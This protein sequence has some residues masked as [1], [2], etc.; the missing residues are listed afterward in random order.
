MSDV[1]W[2]RAV[3]YGHEQGWDRGPTKRRGR[4][5]PRDSVSDDIATL[6]VIDNLDR[7]ESLRA[8]V[9]VELDHL[10]D[11]RLI[12]ASTRED[13]SYEPQSID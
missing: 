12:D 3:W 4:G 9:G 13:R 8:A 2:V 10:G 1:E 6:A 7:R 5:P 11:S